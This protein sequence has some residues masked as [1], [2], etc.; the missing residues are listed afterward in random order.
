MK[1]RESCLP[2]ATNA[3]RLFRNR[4]ISPTPTNSDLADIARIRRN[5]RL[6]A[7]GG[8]VQRLPAAI[9]IKRPDIQPFS[10]QTR[11]HSQTS[12]VGKALNKALR[13]NRR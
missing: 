4:D 1:L 7:R 12:S 6:G 11:R 9:A 5:P 8:K 2:P 13:F 3:W 10:A